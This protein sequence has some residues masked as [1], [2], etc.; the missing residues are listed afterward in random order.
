MAHLRKIQ[1]TQGIFWVEIPSVGLNI[2]CGC[3]GD[4]VKHLMKRGL[5]HPTEKDGI[6]F[7]TGPNVIL[8][9]DV[10]LQNGNISNMAEF[11][12]LQMLYRQ[13]MI[14]PNHPNNTGIKPLIIGLTAQIK[15]PLPPL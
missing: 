6:I 1:I 15:S 4:S 2:L 13:G 7:E 11:P 3:P 14:L 5:I 10:L 12:I 9:S 8:L